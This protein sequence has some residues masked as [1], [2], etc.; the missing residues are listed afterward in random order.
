MNRRLSKK[1]SKI[2][3]KKSHGRTIVVNKEEETRRNGTMGIE[4]YAT[5]TLYGED[6]R[7]ILEELKQKP[8]QKSIENGKK[9]VAYVNKFIK[10]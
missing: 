5:P 1:T 8:S 2:K 10:K 9:L 7:R 6:A 4:V 3:I